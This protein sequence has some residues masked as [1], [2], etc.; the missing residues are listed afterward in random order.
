MTYTTTM[1]AMPKNIELARDLTA[2]LISEMCPLHREN[3]P[4]ERLLDAGDEYELILLW[5]PS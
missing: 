1:G 3:E 4:I 2:H 5:P